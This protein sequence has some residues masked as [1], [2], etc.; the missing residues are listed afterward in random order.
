MASEVD[1]HIISQTVEVGY[2]G[3]VVKLHSA[4][5]ESLL[6]AI[7][8]TENAGG[9]ASVT[10]KVT[11]KREGR[12]AVTVGAVI[13]E[14]IPSPKTLP[15]TTYVGRRGEVTLDDA[16]QGKLPEGLSVVGGDAR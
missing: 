1:F 12:G 9:T 15:M 13:T 8:A 5:D 11:M 2:D 7:R 3:D 16:E 6:K 4:L 10:C 14:K